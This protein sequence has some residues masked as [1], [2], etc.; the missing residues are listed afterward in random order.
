MDIYN[1]E[2]KLVTISLEGEF[3]S[4]IGRDFKNISYSKGFLGIDKF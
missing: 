3:F 2:V 4:L 1:V